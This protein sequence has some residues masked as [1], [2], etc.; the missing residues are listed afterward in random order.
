VRD[1]VKRIIQSQSGSVLLIVVGTIS[2]AMLVGALALGKR[3][4]QS[5]VIRTSGA[6]IEANAYLTSLQKL[7]TSQQFCEQ[8][9]KSNLQTTTAF[10]Y[11]PISQAKPVPLP[12]TM[13]FN[14]IS[15]AAGQNESSVVM[16]GAG[17]GPGSQNA[18]SN[19]VMT[20]APF[21]DLTSGFQYFGVQPSPGPSGIAGNKCFSAMF[22]AGAYLAGPTGQTGGYRAIGSNTVSAI[23]PIVVMTDSTGQFQSCMAGIPSQICAPPTPPTI[24]NFTVTTVNGCTDAWK[25]G[26]Y[27]VSWSTANATNVTMECSSSTQDTTPLPQALSG[28]INQSF[29]T[30]DS[31][32]HGCTLTAYDS[33]GDYVQQP[34]T[35]NFNPGECDK[36]TISIP[37]YPACVNV[38]QSFNIGWQ[39][40]ADNPND[41]ITVSF[42]S[43]SQT[44]A[45]GSEGSSTGTMTFTAPATVPAPNPLV[46]SASDNDPQGF[47]STNVNI[48]VSPTPGP[49]T[50]SVSQA[51]YT[52]DQLPQNVTLTWNAPNADK[53]NITAST[54]PAVGTGLG[55]SGSMAVPVQNATTVY[56]LTAYGGCGD[57]TTATTTATVNVQ[58]CTCVAANEAATTFGQPSQDSCLNLNS[59]CP[60]TL[61]NCTTTPQ[62]Y[63][64]TINYHQ[65]P[66][67]GDHPQGPD[68]QMWEDQSGQWRLY[69]GST[70]HPFNTVM[71]PLNCTSMFFG[72]PSNATITGVQ[73]NYGLV[74]DF[75][76]SVLTDLKLLYGGSVIAD[77]NVNQVCTHKPSVGSHSTGGSA[78]MWGAAL[79]PAIVN[80]PSF[81][82]DFQFT[83]N[84]SRM[85]F[86]GTTTTATVYANIP[87][88]QNGT[89][90]SSAG[91]GMTSSPTTNLCTS[92]TGSVPA[93]DVPSGAWTW[94]CSGT[95]GGTPTSCTTAIPS[96]HLFC[97]IPG[98]NDNEGGT[99]SSIQSQDCGV[100]APTATCLTGFQ[101]NCNGSGGMSITIPYVAC[102]FS[103]CTP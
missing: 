103:G 73:V 10:Q 8:N 55:A 41:A 38:G 29:F 94:T 77:K 67:F 51:N 71:P 19:L 4:M 102:P 27:T 44:V 101:E 89:C 47:S 96:A 48:S 95:C 30:I 16:A 62:Q 83:D 32:F 98:T 28:S 86:E 93:F 53:V 100:C 9:L 90:G 68:P 79:T 15:T 37:T 23:F 5:N 99:C 13:Q 26:S 58:G 45:I 78:D 91:S 82:I 75:G 97:Q 59:S 25:A 81:T 3:V 17:T 35:L 76:Q 2:V 72:V 63:T 20:T 22:H 33:I 85:Y 52:T 12:T 6:N 80:D 64:A 88:G 39:D 42:N 61:N 43:T 24:T 36:S 50:L 54:G 69:G 87:T 70:D 65:C 74:D 7:M 14:R 49:P 57:A 92:G 66:P 84:Q 34:T 56:T 21:I 1:N 11:D 60:G 40:S 46:M 31:G 18:M